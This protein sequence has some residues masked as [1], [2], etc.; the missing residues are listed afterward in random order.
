MDVKLPCNQSN[1]SDLSCLNSLWIL[2][3]WSIN[4][5]ILTVETPFIALDEKFSYRPVFLWG[6]KE[7]TRIQ[8]QSLDALSLK[9][10]D[11]YCTWFRCWASSVSPSRPRDVRPSSTLLLITEQILSKKKASV[12][13]ICML[14]YSVVNSTYLIYKY[15]SKLVQVLLCLHWWRWG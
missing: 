1:Q 4:E 9:F 5:S 12:N 2:K 3:C 7:N 11:G 14:K 8:E 6:P 13:D 15:L 10:H